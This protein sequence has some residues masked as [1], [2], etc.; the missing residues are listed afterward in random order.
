[1]VFSAVFWIGGIA[2][3]FSTADVSLYS[4]LVVLAFN[5]KSGTLHNRAMADIRPILNAVVTASV[6][7]GGVCACGGIPLAD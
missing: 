3:L 6:F 2:A 1:M 5:T 4:L 7:L